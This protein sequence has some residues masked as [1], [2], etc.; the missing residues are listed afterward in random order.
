ML[1]ENMLETINKYRL[2]DRGDRVVLGI[3]GGPDSVCLLHA[4]LSVSSRLDI[5]VFAV[6]I[7][8][9]LR[10]SESD[11][12]ENYVS[13]LCRGLKV[14]VYVRRINIKNFSREKGISLEEAGREARYLIFEE[15]ASELDADKIAVAHNRN[16]QAETL[17]MRLIRGTGLEGLKGMEYK[18]DKIIRP[19]LDIDRLSI[20][21]Y[22]NE[23]KLNPRTDSSNLE[24]VFTR[25]K[26]RLDLIPYINK[27]FNTDITTTLIRMSGILKDD[28]EYLEEK[29]NEGFE[30]CAIKKLEKEACLDISLIQTFHRAIASRII[31]N[32]IRCVKGSAKGIEGQHIHMV[33]DLIDNGRTGAQIQLP[34]G[35]RVEKSYGVVRVYIEGKSN[36]SK[37]FNCKIAVPGETEVV[38]LNIS[39]KADLIEADKNDI[40]LYMKMPSGGLTQFFD[41]EKLK[42]G[43]NI[44]KRQEGDLF[45]P[46][47]SQGGKKL[48]EYFID[49]KVPRRQRDEIPLIAK[50]KDIVWIIGH[51]ISDKFAVTENTKTVLRLMCNPTK[52]E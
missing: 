12:D 35:I 43:I 45:K 20:I 17:L 29:A 32:A 8:H 4:L 52:K 16:D 1:I 34:E 48:K 47:M 5:R 51:K 25:N 23:N 13:E 6:H 2:L 21:K 24:A 27:L 26:I 36:E 15:I 38:C 49:S 10:G 11:M 22:C 39:I 42:E 18:R 3:S 46:L 41:Y 31:R 14:P 37:E 33:L 19:L 28:S 44:R 40:H 30:L 9:L 7:N 50:G